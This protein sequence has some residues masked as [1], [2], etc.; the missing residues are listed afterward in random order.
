MTRDVHPAA[1]LF[2]LFSQEEL[3]DLAADIKVNG[4]LH[5]IVRDD[6]G[7]ILDGRNRLAA[8]EIA[9]IAP[10]FETYEDDDPVSFVL[11]ANLARRHL[12]KGQRA[13]VAA[14]ARR[15]VS[16]RSTQEAA[17]G[18]ETS[19]ARVVQAAVVLDYA[20]DLAD[21]VQTGTRSLDDAYKVARR[22]KERA[23]L[24]QEER[25]LIDEGERLVLKSIDVWTRQAR[26]YHTVVMKGH[27]HQC[28][29][30]E[31][32]LYDIDPEWF[33]GLTDEE[34]AELPPK[35]TNKTKEAWWIRAEDFADEIG[36]DMWRVKA[37]AEAW[38]Q[39]D[40]FTD[41]GWQAKLWEIEA[42]RVGTEEDQ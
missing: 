41:K 9:G 40:H 34:K 11:S 29:S 8:C 7:R 27:E 15:L 24:P 3:T 33:D 21:E 25:D 16:N 10:R 31:R 28:P 5:P 4:L 22:N 13:M 18:A 12:T 42:T 35:C 32:T 19:K 26:L 17:K 36:E 6:Q 37:L 39:R 2:P 1:E 20:P 38:E 23:D 14:K 30:C